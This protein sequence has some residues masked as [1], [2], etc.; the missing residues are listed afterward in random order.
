MKIRFLCIGKTKSDFLKEGVIFYLE[1]LEHYARIEYLELPDIPVRGMNIEN[2]KIKEGELILK[3]LKPED[4]LV[5]LDEKGT[6]F[7]SREFAN[8]LQKK[9]NAGT[10]TLVL[11]VGGAF[12]FSK[13]I[14]G[15]AESLLSFSDM[16][17]PHE[18]IRMFAMEQ[19]YRAHTILK[20]ESY[21]HD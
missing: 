2:I 9:M 17:F 7:S 20:G 18:M 6:R 4:I 5:L 3:Q 14:Y 12:G 13:E 1:R 15:R 11:V 19:L 8:Y 21:H 10:R 16:T